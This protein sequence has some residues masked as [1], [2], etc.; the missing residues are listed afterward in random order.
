MKKLIYLCA[1]LVSSN[2]ACKKDQGGGP[3]GNDHSVNQMDKNFAKK[4]AMSNYAEIQAGQLA[5]TKASNADVQAFGSMMVSDHTA[6]LAELHVIAN[7]LNLYAPDSLDSAHVALQAE[8]MSLSGAAFDS[9]Y[10]LSQ[11]KDH[12][13]AIGLFKNEI[14]QGRNLQLRMYATQKLSTLQMHKATADSLAN[15]LGL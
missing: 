4:A 15:A 14:N 13:V 1:L 2:F 10:V 5:A 3:G 11:V 6:A 9:A 7:S 12:N 8:L